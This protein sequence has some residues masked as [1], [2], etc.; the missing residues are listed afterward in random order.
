[1]QSQDGYFFGD[2]KKISY[3]NVNDDVFSLRSSGM[4]MDLK[5]VSRI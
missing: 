5:N 4:A 1:M 3:L 2:A